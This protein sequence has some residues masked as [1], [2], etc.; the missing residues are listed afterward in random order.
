[1]R[2]AAEQTRLNGE[3]PTKLVALAIRER[4]R[5]SILLASL[6]SFSRQPDVIWYGNG[7]VAKAGAGVMIFLVRAA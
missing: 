7:A 6:P 4:E 1:V 3:T 5:M 2:Q